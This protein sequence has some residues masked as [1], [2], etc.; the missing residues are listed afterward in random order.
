MKPLFW[1]AVNL[2]GFIILVF[3]YNNRDK[4][5]VKRNTGQK[6]FG[7][8]LIVLM[9]FLIFDTGMYLINGLTFYGA[10]IINFVFSIF[11][12]SILPLP[13][14]FLLLYCDYKVFS[15]AIGLKKRLVFYS[16]PSVF[17]AFAAIQSLFTDMIFSI[18]E[19]NV[20]SRGSYFWITVIVGFGYL[21]AYMILSLKIKKRDY[22][23]TPKGS[24]G[25]LYLIPIPPSIFAIIQLVFSGPLL[26]GIGFVI[27]TYYLYVNNI[28]SSEDSRKLSER[29]KNINIANFAV[30]SFVMVI[31]MLLTFDHIVNS[32]SHGF[33]NINEMEII[34][35]FAIIIVM[36]II[37]VFSSNRIVQH[38]I[39]TPLKLLVDS[40]LHMEEDNDHKI[41]GLER[42]D[43]IGLLSNTI[44]EL[45]VKG[46]YDG[47]TGIYNRLYL[48]STLQSIIS[49]LSRTKTKLSVM[50]IDLDF[51]K[52]YNDTYGHIKG[53]EC[54]KKIA[55]TLNN[56]IERKGDFSARYGGEEFVIAL[57]HTDEAGARI[58]G[59]KVLNA[60]RELKIPH[61]NSNEGIVTISIGITTSVIIHTQNWND[62][63]KTADKAL[64]MSKNNGRNRYTFLELM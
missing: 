20:Y 51:F 48:E 58:I 32:A 59:D 50:M 31:V 4:T 45:F 15:D 22:A 14:L 19:N 64:Y 1:V 33:S 57:P 35:S 13:G 7:H 55:Q 41:Y 49:A 24:D 26:I 28:Q 9:L 37:F 61:E 44:Q 6:L 54:L 10:R 2:I 34:L 47:L 38:L 62:Y 52:K 11:Y 29:F 43:E 39:F 23:K 56:V 36:F 46:H 18:S 17:N 27:S 21:A 3:M 16:I 40:L 60:I 63:I 12:Y 25:L 53:D 5:Y 42:D 8:M 30:V